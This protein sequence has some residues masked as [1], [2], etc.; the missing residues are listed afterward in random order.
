MGATIMTGVKRLGKNCLIG[1]G[2]VVIKDVD[3][4]A[5]VAGV[6]AKVLKYK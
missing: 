5:I 3:D 1:A 2:A 6:P 4:N